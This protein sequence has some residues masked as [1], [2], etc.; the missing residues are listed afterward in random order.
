MENNKLNVSKS[1]KIK[2]IKLFVELFLKYEGHN[3]TKIEISRTKREGLKNI[4]DGR[5]WFKICKEFAQK[6]HCR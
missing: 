6:A 4:T 1:A 5:F 3:L 2:D